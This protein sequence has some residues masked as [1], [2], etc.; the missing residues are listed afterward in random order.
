[1]VMHM[2]A[3]RRKTSMSKMLEKILS[4]ANIK[5]ACKR[6]YSNKGASGIDGVTVEEL[7]AYMQEIGAVSRKQSEKEPTNHRQ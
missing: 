7:E 6:V 2:K 5:E 3:E 4:D 1:M